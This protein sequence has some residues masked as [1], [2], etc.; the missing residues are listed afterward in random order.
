MPR[1]RPTPRSPRL[2]S[3]RPGCH[4]PQPHR[5]PWR[6][7]LLAPMGLPLPGVPTTTTGLA[8]SSETLASVWSILQP[9]TP[10][11]PEAALPAR[12]AS[13]RAAHPPWSASPQPMPRPSLPT[14]FATTTPVSALSVPRRRSP[15]RIQTLN[16]CASPLRRAPA[17]AFA[18]HG[19]SASTKSTLSPSGPATSTDH[20][21]GGLL[22]I[23]AASPLWASVVNLLLRND[24]PVPPPPLTLL[25]RQVCALTGLLPCPKS[26]ATLR[27][28]FL[29][30]TEPR[31]DASSSFSATGVLLLP[32]EYAAWCA[33]PD[34]AIAS[35]VRPVPRIL[36]PLTGAHYIIDPIL[37]RAQQMVELTSTLPGVV[38]WSVNGRPIPPQSDGRTF[39]PIEP[40]AWQIRA[41]SPP[42]DLSEAI[43]V[44]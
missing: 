25:R 30:G 7:L 33:S 44:E 13:S 36:N 4:H 16:P 20:P 40:G 39:W 2:F 37:P 21:L 14:S 23:R 31:E 38:Q 22:A 5:R 34:N 24:H 43:T 29:P 27:E 41:Q 32:A 10:V 26:P 9:P 42:A 6:L 17:A 35:Q 3:Q 1:P 15:S 19:P 8:S 28:L 11:W 18:T 12:P